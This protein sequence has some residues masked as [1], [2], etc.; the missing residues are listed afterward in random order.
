MTMHE[1]IRSLIRD[2]DSGDRWGGA[3]LARFSIADAL[4]REGGE[5][6]HEWQYGAGAGNGE[7]EPGDYFAEELGHAINAGNVAL[8][9]LTHAGNVLARYTGILDRAGHSY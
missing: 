6:P 7:V 2:C 1:T 3:M 4:H 8:D 9:D 5:V